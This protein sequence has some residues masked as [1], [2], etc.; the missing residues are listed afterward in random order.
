M[1]KAQPVA[2]PETGSV[3]SLAL[4]RR[5]RAL[6]T[7]A[8][9]TVEALASRARVSAGLVGQVERGVGNPSIGNVHK[10]A[11]ALG[12]S[13][14]ALLEDPAHDAG[15][16]GPSATVVRGDQRKRIAFPRENMVLELL[17]PDLQRS[18]EVIRC[19]MPPGYNTGA[20]P[21]LHHGE[22]CVHVL[23]GRIEVH[24]G[25]ESYLLEPGDTITYDASVTHWWRNAGEQEGEAIGIT[26]PPSF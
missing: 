7:E 4:G 19:V 2:E 10:L 9:L 3:W 22:E 25:S 1:T 21:Y 6:R 20:A 24:V 14:Y 12:V 11:T 26:V 23:R 17:T 13:V 15:E 5:V 16:Q 18:L 8:G